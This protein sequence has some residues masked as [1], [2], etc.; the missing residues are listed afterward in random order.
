MIVPMKEVTLLVYEDEK[1]EALSALRQW[2]LLHI[3][4]REIPSGPGLLSLK[5][6]QKIVEE[7]LGII[8]SLS[9]PSRNAPKRRK[10]ENLSLVARR[11]IDLAKEK[12]TLLSQQKA[13]EKDA[14][15]Y[16]EW[17]KV[18]LADVDYLKGKGIEIVLLRCRRRDLR[19]LE[20]LAYTILKKKGG[21]YLVAVFSEGSFGGVAGCFL[22]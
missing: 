6:E 9:L 18:S 15:W 5:E 13:I 19:S 2:G 21:T 22:S 10:E 16:E 8:K 12:E 11:I 14:A 17:G 3:K 1:E 4:E 20:G 7:A